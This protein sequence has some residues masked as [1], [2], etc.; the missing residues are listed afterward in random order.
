AKAGIPLNVRDKEGRTLMHHA[1]ENGHVEILNQ[2]IQ[3]KQNIRA[4]DNRN[5]TPLEYAERA[6]QQECVEILKKAAEDMIR[7]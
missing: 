4:K 5:R 2:L 3:A 6:E 1:A 7:R